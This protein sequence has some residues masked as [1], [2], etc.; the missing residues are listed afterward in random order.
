MSDTWKKQCE[1]LKNEFIEKNK[2]E[3]KEKIIKKLEENDDD[4]NDVS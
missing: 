1:K 4:E 2:E 3:L